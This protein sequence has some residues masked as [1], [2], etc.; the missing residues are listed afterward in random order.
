MSLTTGGESPTGSSY[1]AIFFPSA[2]TGFG[3]VSSPAVVGADF[4]ISCEEFVCEFW[5]VVAPV[6]SAAPVFGFAPG[7]GPLPASLIDVAPLVGPLPASPFGCAKAVQGTERAIAET[8]KHL[9]SENIYASLCELADST[10]P[11]ANSSWCTLN[12]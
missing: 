8:S 2:S 11:I 1:G 4:C 6:E 12:F 3:F 7:V 5:P 9:P 10:R